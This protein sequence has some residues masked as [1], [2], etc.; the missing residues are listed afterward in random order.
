MNLRSILKLPAFTT[1]AAIEDQSDLLG[2][3]PGRSESL[4]LTLPLIHLEVALR[5][6]V[7]MPDLR[8]AAGEQKHNQITHT[9]S[10]LFSKFIQVSSPARSPYALHATS[11]YPGGGF[12]S[13]ASYVR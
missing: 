1:H 5:S 13:E 11:T 4:G 12:F 7:L 8:S 10:R 3:H 9:A 2:V 6:A